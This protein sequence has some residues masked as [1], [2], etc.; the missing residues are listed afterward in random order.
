MR[1]KTA[2]RKGGG[3]RYAAGVVAAASGRR[4]LLLKAAGQR[5]PL[6]NALDARQQE[7]V[8]MLDP[9]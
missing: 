9:N 8:I 3:L 2:D 6:Q 7:E 5:P 1:S 4:S